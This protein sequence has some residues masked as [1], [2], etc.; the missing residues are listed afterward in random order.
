MRGTSRW[1]LSWLKRDETSAVP[2]PGEQ[3]RVTSL[4]D[5]TGTQQGWVHS[6]HQLFQAAGADGAQPAVRRLGFPSGFICVL[7][8]LLLYWVVLLCSE[9]SA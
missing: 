6:H 4:G 2:S 8:M 3:W 9:C 5:F 1:E 7:G